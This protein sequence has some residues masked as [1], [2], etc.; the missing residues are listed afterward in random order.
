ML[1]E[2]SLLLEL[3]SGVCWNFRIL[4]KKNCKEIQ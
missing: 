4:E 3:I 1:V 2:M